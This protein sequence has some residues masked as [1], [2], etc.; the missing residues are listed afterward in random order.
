VEC[1]GRGSKREKKEGGR[2]EP[3]K[4]RCL[5]AG[6]LL[7]D[8]IEFGFPSLSSLLFS[9]FSLSLSL[10]LSHTQRD[11]DKGRIE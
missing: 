11:T 1:N 3:K 5:R 8:P 7:D 10:S 9:C 6:R 4:K 2:G